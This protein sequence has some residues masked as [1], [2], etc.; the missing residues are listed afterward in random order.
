MAE[1][2]PTL[3][4]LCSL[5]SPKGLEGTSFVPLLEDPSQPWKKAA[6]IQVA[7]GRSHDVMGRSV[8]TERFRYTEWDF[9]KAGVE[10]YDHEMDPD[11]FHNL[12]EDPAHAKD[13][14]ALHELICDRKPNTTVA[15]AGGN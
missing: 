2:D 7:H 13:R 1:A 3:T 5:P 14:A 11:E 6:F 9:G 8:R 10:L 12:A 4:Q 15:P